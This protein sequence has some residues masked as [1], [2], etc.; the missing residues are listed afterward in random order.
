[1]AA[2][3]FTKG[4]DDDM[5]K[6]HEAARKGYH[7]IIVRMVGKGVSPNIANKYGCTALHLACKHGHRE[8]VRVLN[9][10]NAEA[11]PWHGRYPV[12]VAVAA[13]EFDVLRELLLGA[14][15][16]GGA[17]EMANQAD[18]GATETFGETILAAGTSQLT[19]L[20]YACLMRRD[21]LAGVLLEYGASLVNRDSTGLL[22]VMHALDDVA[23]LRFLLRHPAAASAG[24]LTQRN[25]HGA[26]LL[27]QALAR[28]LPQSAALVLAMLQSDTQEALAA[29][30]LIEDE[31]KVR[32][33]D[34]I[35]QL[36]ETDFLAAVLPA[37]EK[38]EFMEMKFHD[39]KNVHPERIAW[40]IPADAA[41]QTQLPSNVNSEAVH[42]RAPARKETTMQLLQARLDELTA[43]D[44]EQAL[45]DAA[46][47]PE[48]KGG[49][50]YYKHKNPY[51]R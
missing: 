20:H 12:H 39:G 46:A 48:K 21:D 33:F 38:A 42:L 47:S 19:P 7:D 43:G 50:G 13:G 36:G 15:V 8:A 18:E 30:V 6:L 1:M 29:A 3:Q 25:R 45:K 17:A 4:N 9:M 10:H 27:H 22:P 14:D 37:V 32:P 2:P 11:V 24:L 41:S 28:A 44:A 35:V 23:M 51:A 16:R 26:T 34:S 49:G 5:V 40:R 31:A